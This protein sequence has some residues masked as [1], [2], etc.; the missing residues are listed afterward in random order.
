MTIK[1]QTSS[2]C[3]MLAGAARK[4]LLLGLGVT[5]VLVENITEMVENA[6]PYSE[7]LVERGEKTSHEIN[8]A[9][10]VRRQEIRH[11]AKANG[12]VKEA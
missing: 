12:H 1:E 7:Q 11:R 3:R 5:A 4:T 8:E 9:L 2:V 10:E 6:G